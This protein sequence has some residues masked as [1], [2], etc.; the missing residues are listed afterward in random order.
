MVALCNRVDNIIFSSCG[1]Y[2]LFFLA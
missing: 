2:L 1:F